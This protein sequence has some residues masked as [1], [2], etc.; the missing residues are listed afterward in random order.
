MKNSLRFLAIA[1]LTIACATSATS[2]NKKQPPQEQTPAVEQDPA[3]MRGLFFPT[4][5]DI[6]NGME[7]ATDSCNRCH[8]AE[9]A[10]EDPSLPNLNGQHSLY[11]F[12][13]LQEYKASG[14][15]SPEM[16]KT[17]RFLS[18]DALRMVATYYN[19]LPA[20]RVDSEAVLQGA[21]DP[22]MFDPVL[23]GQAATKRCGMCHG[24]TGN[25]T[26][27]G[28]PNLT[29]QSPDVFIA[30]MNF[31]RDGHRPKS[32]MTKFALAADAEAIK[33]MA[34]FYALQAPETTPNAGVGDA[35]AGAAL[36]ADCSGCHGVNGNTTSATMPT[37]A[38]QEPAYM[39]GAMKEY[40][41]DERRHEQMKGA[42]ADLSETD[43]NDLATYY[44]AQQPVPRK[45]FRP[46]TL[47]EWIARCNR[48]HGMNGNSQNPAIPILAG[49]RAAYILKS[50]EA[51]SREERHHSIMTAMTKPMRPDQFEGIAVHYA[52]QQPKSIMYVELPSSITTNK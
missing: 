4:A 33:N 2:A 13:K 39:V 6:Q 24:K 44:A 10:A 29:G 16:V 25:A 18:D 27:S 17:I 51:Y 47:D 34:L 36:A 9:A 48:C 26:R 7:L 45:V 32:T 31:Y 52:A 3:F 35:E 1:L 22:A 5:A 15:G 43:L 38:G 21:P 12:N 19:S 14:Y 28:M 41:A 42:V 50:L 37:L 11:L 20:P 49:Q 46:S 8:G 23:L 30:A 40:A